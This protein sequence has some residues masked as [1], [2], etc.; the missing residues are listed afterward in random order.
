[1]STEPEVIHVHIGEAKLGAPHSVL[2]AILGSCVGIGLIWRKQN[3]IALAHCLLP[4]GKSQQK[5]KFVNEA[6]DSLLELIGASHDSWK[7]IEAVVAGGANMYQD[8]GPNGLRVGNL[9]IAAALK[10]LSEKKIKI[11]FQDTG[12]EHGRQLILDVDSGQY[13]VRILKGL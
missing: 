1:M 7:E 6:V 5:A 3:K 11:I 12:K 2:K 9:N 4:E 8:I 13:D 10:Y